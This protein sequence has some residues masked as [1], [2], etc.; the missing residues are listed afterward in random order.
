[1]GLRSRFVRYAALVNLILHV[2]AGEN[3]PMADELAQTI[4]MLWSI[5]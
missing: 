5:P 1:M 4:D 3:E 2:C